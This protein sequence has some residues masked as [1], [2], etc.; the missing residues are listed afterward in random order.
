MPGIIQRELIVKEWPGSEIERTTT[1]VGTPANNYTLTTSLEL[2]ADIAY[3]K[4][5]DLTG[6]PLI[7]TP[8]SEE[9]IVKSVNTTTKNLV[10]GTATLATVTLSQEIDILFP[11]LTTLY[12]IT[13]DQVLNGLLN[14]YNIDPNWANSGT[15]L[16]P[17][18]ATL[19]LQIDSLN[20]LNGIVTTNGS[21][22]FS[23]S[24]ALPNGTTATT[25][26]PGDNSTNLATTAYTDAAVEAE[27]F[28]DRTGTEISPHN[29]NDDLVMDTGFVS[30]DSLKV[31]DTDDS[32]LL[33]L[34]W[35]EDDSADRT[36]YFL[37]SG[38]DRS[39]TISGD[40]TIN[41]NFS[42][43]G[44]P[45]LSGLTLGSLT[46]ADGIVQT[47]GSGVLSS[48]TTLPDGTTATTQ[49]QGDNSTNLATTAYVDAATYWQR[50]GIDLSPATIGDNIDIAT[51]G[52]KDNDVTTAIAL[53]DGSNTSFNTTNKTIVG[54]VNELDDIV[55]RKDGSVALTAN[56]DAGNYTI[57]ADT[58]DADT[59]YEIGSAP[60]L[61]RGPA[62]LDNNYIVGN[63]GTSLSQVAAYEGEDN[64][65]I[66]TNSG[67]AQTTG[68]WNVFI[69]SDAGAS[70]TTSYAN[71][72][73][74][75][76]SIASLTTDTNVW[77]IGIGFS[78][79]E[80]LTGGGSNIA[81]GNNVLAL[82]TTG[83]ANVGVGHGCLYSNTADHNV[84]IGNNAGSDTT[85][86]EKNVY[87]G[88][89]SGYRTGT[90]DNNIM[91]GY[92]AGGHGTTYN[93]SGCIFI[94]YQAGLNESTSNKL[95]IDN[96]SSA[97]PLIYGEFDNDQLTVNGGLTINGDLYLKRTASA[98]DYNPSALTSDDVIAITDTSSARAVTISTEDVQSGSTSN[99]R[100]MTVKDESGNA[101][102][103]N[104]TVSLESGNID[105]SASYVIDGDY[106]SVTI[107]LDGTN[108]FT[109]S[110]NIAGGTSYWDRTGT[111][112]EPDTAND[113][114]DMGSGTIVT[115]GN[116]T[117]HNLVLS[118]TTPML[119]FN[120]DSND[121]FILKTSGD[122]DFHLYNTVSGDSALFKF[123]TNDGDGTDTIGLHVFGVGTTA[124]QSNN[125]SLKMEYSSGYTLFQI[126]SSN[127]G[128][129]TL[130][131]LRLG[132]GTKVTS[133][134]LSL[135]TDGRVG[136][137][138][139]APLAQL[140]I[141]QKEDDEAIPVLALDQA[142]ISEGFINFIGSD[143][144]VISESTN[145]TESVR[146]EIN[147]VVRR[148]ALYADA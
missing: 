123:F 78:T 130:R 23:S 147:G 86:A 142:D 36:L 62:G 98:T 76:K 94:G 24:T 64:I 112:I 7:W 80:L 126:Y 4:L 135:S 103:N 52:L 10:F 143:R 110:N 38:A 95:Y 101:G 145:S 97:T 25:Q 93:Q 28:W 39:F 26:S 43:T 148:L 127:S 11:F 49:S 128:T 22:L 74:G 91:I 136:M 2:I 102:T 125:E 20:V 13:V 58:F 55:L 54:S 114:L 87:I 56:W 27:N 82:T 45:T 1:L 31:N 68:Y 72:G 104:I 141:D 139:A 37:V 9:V 21:G 146:V 100:I 3:Y 113:N 111:T 65:F 15:Y 75:Y 30:A 116:I 144:G 140:H 124:S 117:G 48:S 132:A 35:N 133:N 138:V 16:S 29:A 47:N 17:K 6:S 131:P 44:S 122:D 137:T 105:G 19:G 5:F 83:G 85:S 42:S 34:M 57:T 12:D 71:I 51:G 67:L 79:L 118:G 115:S 129:G 108:G 63:G 66:G 77:N 121:P 120:D 14:E 33:S 134:Q 88:H 84:A 99:P 106:E 81:I 32:N 107:Y 70:I 40:S 60:A 89:Y 109:V 73:I 96:S 8:T 92:Y 90:G 41:G 18:L 50:I 119:H 53:G 61:N 69:G 46:V 59:G